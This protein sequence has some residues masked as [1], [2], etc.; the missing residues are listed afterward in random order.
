MKKAEVILEY[1]NLIERPPA[2]PAALY[3]Q[4]CSNDESTIKHW[5]HIW[6]ANITANKSRFGSFAER[7]ISSE[8]QKYQYGPAIVAG[9]GPSLKGNAHDL[10]NR[11]RIPLISCLHNFHYFEDL[12]L[13]PEYY[14]TLDA[15]PVTIE[16]VTE[17]GT[18]SVD[19]YWDRT[20]DRTLI[21][22]I[23]TDPRL[24]EKW[25]GK[26]LFFNSPLPNAELIK[27]IDEI[28]E[29]NHFLSTGGNVLG[30]C[31]YFAKTILGAHQI[32]YTGAD[33]CF[34]YD[35]RFHAWDSKYDANMGQTL[36][37]TDIY[38]MKRKT[39]PSYF[40]FKAYFDSVAMRAP[41]I[42]YN[43]SEGGCL[44]SYPEGNIAAFRYM[45]LKDCLK[46]FNINDELKEQMADA[47]AQKKILYS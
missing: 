18:K 3:Q 5:W 2:T 47:K 23:A 30:A 45:D 37:C 9:Y 38:G 36:W 44:G 35:Y 1:Q 33:F 32:I 6:L 43:C 11:G 34:G 15:G 24:L 41:G 12:E 17:G 14:V 31:L 39:W 28:E 46:M 19:E 20:K 40:N 4:A 26:I 21:A 29:F 25:Q 8:F 16:E 42:Y 22:F 13:N 10:R 7:S 27:K